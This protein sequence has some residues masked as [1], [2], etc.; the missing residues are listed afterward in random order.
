MLH[1]D[2]TPFPQ[3]TS[4]RLV[5]RQLTVADADA[6]TVLRNNAIVN[7][8][9]DRPKT[10]TPA[11]ALRFIDKINDGIDNNVS[12]YWVI[13]LRENHQL[14]GTI[15]LW[16]IVAEDDAAEIGYELHPDFH[17]KGIMH[18]AINAVIDFGFNTMQLKVITGFTS[19]ANT[20]SIKSLERNNFKLD[21]AG[22]YSD[23]NNE[24]EIVYVLEKK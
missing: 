2:F 17:G 13:S 3:L 12:I 8:Y 18:E 10:T 4:R 9:L 22:K 15:C 20:A 19:P 23:S 5:L 7:Q 6:I 1:L 14:I 16:N 11:E 24:G 21:V